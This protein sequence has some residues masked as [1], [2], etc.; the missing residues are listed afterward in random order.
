MPANKKI[1]ISVLVNN[2]NKINSIL[3]ILQKH[4]TLNKNLIINWIKII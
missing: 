3:T 4:K 1:I 2:F